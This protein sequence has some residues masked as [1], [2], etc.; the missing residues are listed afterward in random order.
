MGIRIPPA[1]NGNACLG[2]EKGTIVP[3]GLTGSMFHH[4][5]GALHTN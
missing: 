1:T 2:E 4:K 3:R 5:E